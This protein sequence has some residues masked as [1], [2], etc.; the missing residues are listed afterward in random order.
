MLA[1]VTV[2]AVLFATTWTIAALA[3]GCSR[4]FAAP[5]EEFTS[6]CTPGPMVVGA[7][8][9]DADGVPLG[10]AVGARCVAGSHPA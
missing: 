6:T 3:E 8:E 9:G 5:A 7:G 4:R 1:P 2:S 10:A